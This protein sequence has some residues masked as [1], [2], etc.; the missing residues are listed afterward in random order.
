MKVRRPLLVLL[1]LTL[2]AGCAGGP[3]PTWTFTQ[4]SGVPPTEDPGIGSRP[5]VSAGAPAP[6]GM[7][8]AAPGLSPVVL[9]STPAT[10]SASPGPRAVRV[11]ELEETKDLTIV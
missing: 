7:T 6:T 8:P 5:S 2:T 3:A 11:I 9:P 4:P 10:A 1:A